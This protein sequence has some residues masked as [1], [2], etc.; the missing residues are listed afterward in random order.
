MKLI[1]LKDFQKQTKCSLKFF[2]SINQKKWRLYAVN[3]DVESEEKNPPFIDVQI[4]RE[5][6]RAKLLHDTHYEAW[7]YLF[8]KEAQEEQKSKD[9]SKDYTEDNIYN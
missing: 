5:N 6:K 3:G 2:V 8:P 9:Y 4:E 1:A 7:A